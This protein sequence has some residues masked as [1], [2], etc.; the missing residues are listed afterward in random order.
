MSL[1]MPR[2]FHFS[3]YTFHFAL[4]SLSLLATPAFAWDA[5]VLLA[6]GRKLEQVSLKP[7]PSP[8]QVLL[9]GGSEG[10]LTVDAR[11]LLVVD[12][13]KHPT[14]PV[15]PTLRLANGDQVFGKVTFPSARQVKVAAGWGSLTAPLSWCTAI[16]LKEKASLPERPARD[17]VVLEKDRVEGE[18]QGVTAG[19]VN[20]EL[21]S[22]KPVPLDIARVYGMALKPRDRPADTR[23]GLVLSIDLGGGE[24]LTGRWVKLDADVLTVKLD[25][26][27][28]L[29]IPIASISSVEVKNGKLVYLS[30]LKPAEVRETPYLDGSFPLR[31]DRSVAGRPLRL[32]GKTFRRGLGVH[33]KSDLTYTLDG[34]YQTFNATIGVDDAVTG[35]GSVIFR[36]FGDDKL[37]YESPIMRGGDT[38]QEVKVPVKGVLLLRLEVDYADNGDVADHADWAEARLLRQ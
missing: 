9:E 14:R 8:T 29:D 25:W 35:Q 28:P 22:G 33:S 23:S 18:I 26:D 4:L 17:I 7:G 21:G 31:A 12:F 19:K 11:D 1:P 15:E 24:R 36:V 34:G 2:I 13:G 27:R 30:D 5:S 3:S 37:L 32:G 38:P 20:I 10:S 6:D 16:R